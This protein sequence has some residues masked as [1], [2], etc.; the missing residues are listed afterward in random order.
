M[1]HQEGSQ[2]QPPR[3]PAPL[4]IGGAQSGRG[5]SLLR[6]VLPEFLSLPGLNYGRKYKPHSEAVVRLFHAFGRIS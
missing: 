5:R 2:I 3:V 6:T 4:A 1:T